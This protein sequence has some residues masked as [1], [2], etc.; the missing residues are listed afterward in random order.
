M[1][2][3]L[4]S[5]ESFDIF[6]KTEVQYEIERK[7]ILK[8]IPDE[9]KND[10]AKV[11]LISFYLTEELHSS[12][13]QRI[14]LEKTDDN[15][16]IIQTTKTPTG[17]SGVR[18]ELEA[19]LTVDEFK[20]HTDFITHYIKKTRYV[21]YIDGY[22]WEIDDFHNIKLVMAEVE[23]LTTD[24]KNSGKARNELFNIEIPAIIQHNLIYEVTDLDSFSNKLLAIK[25]NDNIETLYKSFL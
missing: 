18:Q 15:I 1:T 16:K 9:F 14:R 21:K 7:F 11:E 10:A 5:Q 17:T 13:A 6:N 23:M 25:I 12:V 24:L 2:T 3:N 8:N 22:K 4:T 19:E 20:K